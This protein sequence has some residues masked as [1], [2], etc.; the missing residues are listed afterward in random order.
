MKLCKCDFYI[1]WP[2]S[3]DVADLRRFIIEIL[4]KKGEVIRWSIVEIKDFENSFKAKKIRI[5]AVLS[6]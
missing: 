2:N 5:N 4:I 1:D 6:I 3:I